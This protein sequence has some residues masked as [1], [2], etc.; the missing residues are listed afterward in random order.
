MPHLRKPAA[1][2]VRAFLAAQQSADFS[3]VHV[4]D[5]AATPP[6]GW[7]V[8]RTRARLGK[9][10]AVFDTAVAALRRWEQFNLGWVGASPTDTPIEVGRIVGIQACTGGVWWLNAC[11]IIYTIDEQQCDLRRFGFAYGTLPGHAEAGEERFLIEWNERTGEVWYDILAFSRPNH[12]LAKLLFPI[13]RMF[14]RRFARESA[15]AMRR[16]VKRA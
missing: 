14:Q 6:V 11:R 3:Y 12:L 9:G 15:A 2:Q 16:A 7:S 1:A 10:Q 4:G 8:D 13:A 5:T